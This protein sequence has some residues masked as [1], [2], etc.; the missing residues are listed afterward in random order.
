MIIRNYILS[1]DEKKLYF[2]P[3]NKVNNFF[4]KHILYDINIFLIFLL[5]YFN[6]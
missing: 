3:I 4:V 5:N 1:S 2:L 6:F